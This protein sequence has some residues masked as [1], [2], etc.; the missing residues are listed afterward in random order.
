VGRIKDR[1]GF[2]DDGVGVS[3]TDPFPLVHRSVV[4]LVDDQPIVAEAVR[5]MLVDEPDME[6]HYCADPREALQTAREI[7]ATVVLQDL[8]MPDVDGLTV[9]RSFRVHPEAQITPI[10]VL[11]TRDHPLD[12][13]AAFSAGATDYLVKLP[14]KIELVARIRAH[15]KSYLA[16]VQRD[17]A[18]KSL[19]AMKRQL[20]ETNEAL[21]QMSI[22]D[23]LTGIANRR[24]FDEVLENE[25]AR[26]QRLGTEIS[27]VLIDIDHFKLYN[28]TCGHLLGDECLRKVATALHGTALR[29]TDLVGRYGGEE[30]VVLLPDTPSAGARE[31]AERMQASVAALALPHPAPAAKGTVTISQGIA[32]MRPG[33]A[34]D[35]NMLVSRADAAL[36]R[37]KRAGRN[38]HETHVD[39]PR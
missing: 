32:S 11:S 38:R 28:D 27:I 36:Y 4:L 13:S 34:D 6:F 31:V 21:R 35:S 25:W 26:A 18:Y 37:A 39:A 12:K 9:V 33:T 2:V 20:E 19:R 14:D 7:S 22:V 1:R 8:V 10:I 30:F 15:S 23:A 5:R 3:Q 29:P 16:Q 17:E 24:R